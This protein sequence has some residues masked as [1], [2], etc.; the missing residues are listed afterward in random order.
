MWTVAANWSLDCFFVS[1]GKGSKDSVKYVINS[2]TSKVACLYWH[3][4]IPP[5]FSLPCFQD[6][7]WVSCV[8]IQSNESLMMLL[9][10][11]Y[12]L[13]LKCNIGI[14]YY[15]GRLQGSQNLLLNFSLHT[16][17]SVIRNGILKCWPNQISSLPTQEQPHIHTVQ[18]TTYFL[19][20]FG[21]LNITFKMVTIILTVTRQLN[22]RTRQ[23]L[24]KPRYFQAWPRL[25]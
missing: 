6:F 23:Y 25:G 5:N 24:D 13:Y 1:I 3:F 20:H 8:L 2:T 15:L 7:W 22:F 11:L 4:N 14:N 17:W 10:V 9:F 12:T 16:N 21:Y 18:N 19:S